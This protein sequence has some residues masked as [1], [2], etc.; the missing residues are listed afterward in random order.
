MNNE[1]L[2]RAECDAMRGIAIIGIFL[3]NYCHWLPG[4]VRENEYQYF[5]H[6]VDGLQVSLLIQT[7]CYQYTYSPSSATTESLYSS[8]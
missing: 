1:L 4:I 8:S 5:Q 6:N 3:H 2:T 7:Y